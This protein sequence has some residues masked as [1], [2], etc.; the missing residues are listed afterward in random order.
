[1]RFLLVIHCYYTCYRETQLTLINGTEGHVRKNKQKT[2][3]FLTAAVAIHVV[4]MTF[5]Q[6]KLKTFAINS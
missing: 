4:K 1:M 6:V 3:L 2:H 5:L